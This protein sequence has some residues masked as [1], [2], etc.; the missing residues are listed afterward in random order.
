MT[1]GLDQAQWY[2]ADVPRLGKD[3]LGVWLSGW[4]WNSS[5]GKERWQEGFV[6]D[7]CRGSML[8]QPWSDASWLSP[9]ERK[10]MAEF[11]ALLK[12]Q[13]GCFRNSRFVLGNPWKGEPYG[14][15]CSN[16]KRAFSP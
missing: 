14:Y 3:S 8:A 7:M 10:Q 6:M 13:P 4:E 1:V 15:V 12:G 5:I 11:I 2:A 16:G 9:D